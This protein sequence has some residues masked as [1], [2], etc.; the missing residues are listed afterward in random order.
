MSLL[1]TVLLAALTLAPATET[2]TDAIDSR[3]FQ[4]N[5]LWSF[6]N[7]TEPLRA[8]FTR[9]EREAKWDVV[10]YFRFDGTDHEYRGVAEGELDHGELSGTVK[11]E[12]R[13]RTFTF[14]GEFEEGTF[15]G[16]HAEL[17]GGGQRDTGTLTLEAE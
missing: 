2:A 13:R 11:N 9:S 10:F 14:Q 1:T 12:N 16:H 5:Y 15:T 3:A 17:R 7:E 6:N 4:G 8:V